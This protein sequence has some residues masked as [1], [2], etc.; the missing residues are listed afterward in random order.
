M[1]AWSLGVITVV[2]P[3]RGPAG[4]YVPP[5]WLFPRSPAGRASRMFRSL[6]WDFLLS[7]VSVIQ[8][9]VGLCTPPSFPPPASRIEYDLVIVV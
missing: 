4:G 6:F 3:L 7:A 5:G 1:P 8:L 2:T 9:I